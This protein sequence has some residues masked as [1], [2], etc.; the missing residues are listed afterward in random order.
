MENK[1]RVLT[2]NKSIMKHSGFYNVDTKWS[3][4][5]SNLS[6]YHV[7]HIYIDFEPIHS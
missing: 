5:M 2:I 1:P 4:F 6:M 7:Y 3:T